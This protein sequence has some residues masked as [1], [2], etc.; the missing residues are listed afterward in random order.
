M[1]LPSRRTFMQSTLAMLALAACRPEVRRVPALQLDA[2]APWRQRFRT[3]HILW[4]RVARR[5]PTR[6]VAVSNRSGVDQLY[7]WDVPTGALR[8]LTDT[9]EGVQ[10]ARI[11]P[12]GRHIYYR[13]DPGGSEI[14]HIVRIPFEGGPALDLTPDMPPYACWGGNLS[15]AGNLLAF[16]AASKAFHQVCCIDL[17]PGDAVGA[18]RIIYQSRRELWTPI[19]SAD[20]TLVVVPSTERAGKRQPSLLAFDASVGTQVAELWDGRGVGL[21]P[22]MF[23][24][25]SGDAR[26][27]GITNR[28]GAHRP[29]LWDV[30]SGE[31]Q[32]FLLPE[33]DGEVYPRDWSVEHQ[34]V[35]LCQFAGA[36]Q[37][38]FLLDLGS[39]ILT[40][41]E[42][43]AGTF[44]AMYVQRRDGAIIT[45]WQDASHPP[46]IIALDGTTGRHVR[47]VLEA[48]VP[49]ASCPWRSVQFQ[50][51]DGQSI[52]GW[53]GLPD[54]PGPFPAIL[55]V[56]GGPQS[57][58]T[59][60][61]FPR[62][63]AWMD[64]GF[65][66]LTINYR[67]ST[68]FGRA[69]AEQIWGDL[70]HWELEDIV[71]ARSW[72]IGQ[73][74]ARPDQVLLT[75]RSYGGYLTLLA[76]GKRPALW[77]GGMAHVAIGDFRL[78]YADASE[79]LRQWT[80]AMLGGT[81]EEKPEQ[82]RISSPI[83]YAEHVRAPL[84][85]IQGRHDTRTP[86][87]QLEAY[88]EKL[89]SLGK[90]VEAYWYDAGHLTARQ[91]RAIEDMERMLR[92]ALR[93]LG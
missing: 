31:R 12:D 44:A 15:R 66:Y 89:Q 30:R 5:A 4:A 22:I 2:T 72:L 79:S 92:F 16:V 40:P 48:G 23:S 46:C 83:T 78:Q 65:A 62:S 77:A 58:M 75:G 39:G 68:T 57:V 86:A 81:P 42:H 27:L 24:T 50:S 49:P 84:L 43:P 69:F 6:G 41:L 87:R 33:L 20:G 59:E 9:A 56:H 85:M 35:L 53:L 8:Q 80:V 29:L 82:Y 28:S 70:G 45:Q 93:V 19:V 32:D 71:A 25:R 63:Q 7:A 51:S 17:G 14:G 91:D 73:G 67:G 54:G 1:S 61:F 64:H 10:D 21:A 18:P 52:Q 90:P 3:P 34:T 88:I 11:S 37:R 26:L 38:L 60:T 36:R 76:L 74:I 55:E 13:E 47:T